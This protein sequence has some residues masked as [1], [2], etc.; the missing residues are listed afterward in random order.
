[1]KKWTLWTGW[2]V[3]TAALLMCQA[4]FGA[5]YYYKALIQVT[6]NPPA[7]AA[8][9]ADG[10]VRG[11]QT[12]ASITNAQKQI[13]TTNSVPA[14]TTNLYTHLSLYGLTNVNA[15]KFGTNDLGSPSNTVVLEMTPDHFVTV[16]TLSNWATVTYLTNQTT[17]TTPI[18]VRVPHTSLSLVEQSN[19]VNGVAGIVG[20]TNATNR[21]PPTAPMLGNFVNTTTSQIVSNKNLTGGSLSN[22]TARLVAVPNYGLSVVGTQL[23]SEVTFDNN[24]G[25]YFTMRVGA[26]SNRIARFIDL[27]N[28]FNNLL[29]S[30]IPNEV[31]ITRTSSLAKPLRLLSNARFNLE[32]NIGDQYAGSFVFSPGST[33]EEQFNF[34]GQ[35][36]T[37]VLGSPVY[38]ATKSTNTVTAFRSFS[39]TD[40]Y[41]DLTRRHGNLELATNVPI[42]YPYLLGADIESPTIEGEWVNAGPM[43]MPSTTMAGVAAGNNVIT[44][45][46]LNRVKIAATGGAAYINGIT[47][48]T[49]THADGDWMRIENGSGYPLT[50][51]NNSAF[52]PIP[53]DR[54][55]TVNQVSNVVVQPGGFAL[56]TWDAVVSRWAVLYPEE[57]SAV[58]VTNAVG[59][60]V[61]N[62]VATVA[63]AATSGTGV[64]TLLTVPKFA[65]TNAVPA[66]TNIA[67]SWVPVVVD[68]TTNGFLK[69][70]R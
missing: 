59:P 48:T 10:D 58:Q 14:A 21:V 57:I 35:K 17:G 61:S 9:S 55:R 18:A 1:M 30:S 27:T 11:W 70:F 26:S 47:N 51:V 19:V 3:W 52:D 34:T 6:T 23:F 24:E 15:V 53:I 66:E 12:L 36:W 32:D 37:M 4:S 2:T 67:W 40:F 42:Y 49:R 50:F 7:T 33:N 28:A 68:G 38:S 64:N 16:T 46:A 5:T 22:V 41:Y 20:D 31:S 8:V 65:S 29:T 69:I 13:A 63:I 54:L 60:Y 44:V 39:T 56:L 62:Y 45:P 43:S 25:E